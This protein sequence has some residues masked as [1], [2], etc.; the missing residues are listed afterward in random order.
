MGNA[1]AMQNR[2][3]EKPSRL[4]AGI[5]SM[6]EVGLGLCWASGHCCLA[7]FQWSSTIGIY[8][9]STNI[10]FPR[11]LIFM[12]CLTKLFHIRCLYTHSQSG[13]PI[14]I[15]ESDECHHQIKINQ[16]TTT[17]TLYIIHM[18]H[19]INR[20]TFTDSSSRRQVGVFWITVPWT[21]PQHICY[22]SQCT[23]FS[24]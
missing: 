23:M 1:R 10:P 6:Q 17:Y 4:S 24:R 9:A 12:D 15:S 2:A 16:W 11:F 20:I 18:I 14:L 5:A 7:F 19:I 3:K 22:R 8:L 21:T 13:G